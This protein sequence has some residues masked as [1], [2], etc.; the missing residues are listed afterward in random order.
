[1]DDIELR[2]FAEEGGERQ[3]ADERAKAKVSWSSSFWHFWKTYVCVTIDEDDCRDH[4]ALERTFLA[5]IRTASAFG[6]F[7]VALAQLFRLNTTSD[8]GITPSTLKVGKG[9]GAAVEIIAI[10][11]ILLGAGYFVKQQMKLMEDAIIAR[12]YEIWVMLGMSFAVSV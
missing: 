9:L 4:L 8:G 2:D 7:G 5:Y 1:M 12:G 6:Q 10:V 3:D 11:F